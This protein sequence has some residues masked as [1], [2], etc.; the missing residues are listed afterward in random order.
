MM[1]TPCTVWEAGQ[2]ARENNAA[3]KGKTREEIRQMEAESR[4][5][6]SRLA[7][8]SL[9]RKQQAESDARYAM[10]PDH[11]FRKEA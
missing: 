10:L 11:M 4:A 8:A 1:L 3:R 2:T 9:T 5:K 7:Q 6:W